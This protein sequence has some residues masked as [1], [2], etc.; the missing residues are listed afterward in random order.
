M[1]H[2]LPLL[3]LILILFSCNTSEVK[4][5]PSKIHKDL[6]LSDLHS[7]ISKDVDGKLWIQ[8]DSVL[9]PEMD[10]KEG[11]GLSE[12]LPE[13]GSTDSSFVLNFGK[14]DLNGFLY[15][16]FISYDDYRYPQAVYFKKKAEVVMGSCSIPI[17][18]MTGKYDMI[19]WEEKGLGVMGYLWSMKR[20]LLFMM[21]DL[22]FQDQHP[23]KKEQV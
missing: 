16:G 23:S 14:K 9:Y 10:L 12:I 7:H 22:L 1:K 8:I 5:D 20:V 21:A 4:E 18:D 3:A 11:Y 17:A 19:G 15:F 2:L 13:I 6:E